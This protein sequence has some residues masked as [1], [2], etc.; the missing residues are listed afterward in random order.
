MLELPSITRSFFRTPVVLAIA[1]LVLTIVALGGCNRNQTRTATL[2]TDRT[3]LAA[4]AELYNAAQERYKIHVEH[5]PAP[6]DALLERQEHPDLVVGDYLANE[7]TFEHFASID[8]VLTSA[9]LSEADFYPGLLELGRQG[10]ETRLLPVSFNLPAVMFRDTFLNEDLDQFHVSMQHLRETGAEFNETSDD[11]YVR[12][13]FS[14][15]WDGEFLYVTAMSFGANFRE[16]GR[17]NAAWNHGSLNEAVDHVR[18]W[19]EEVNGGF[20][21]ED[22]FE[23]RYLYDPPYQLLQSDRIRFAYTTAARFYTGAERNRRG[24]D[25]RWLSRNGSIPVLEDITYIGVPRE[26]QNAEA[27]RDFVRWL[28]SRET[29]EE[30]LRAA[31]HKRIEEFGIA[32]GFSSLVSTNHD[33]LP[34]TYESLLGRIPPPSL[35][36]FPHRVPKDWDGIKEDV[37]HPWLDREL[38]GETSAEE[39]AGDIR[40]WIFQKGD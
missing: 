21:A 23:E 11:R 28:F 30:L 26:A 27:G 35:L 29:Q 22:E 34:A 10:D 36:E 13:G 3:S 6:A 38:T 40:S 25:V 31:V 2:W 15:R 17:R 5:T 12:M 16:Q 19:V 20:D 1:V 39:L 14:P 33:V 4:Y 8:D 32:G 7:S 18:Q 9:E 24:V 37:I